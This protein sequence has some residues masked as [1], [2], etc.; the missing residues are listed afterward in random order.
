M[1]I[2]VIAAEKAEGD[3]PD[4]TQDLE[5]ESLP[6]E[7]HAFEDAQEL[8]TP[9]SKDISTIIQ[10]CLKDVKKCNSK[11]AIKALSKLIAV[12]EYVQLCAWYKKHNTCKQPCLA[13]SVAIVCSMGKGP[14]F[15]RQIRHLELYLK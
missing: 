4:L 6:L 1:Q 13:A 8:F 9:E 5:Q 15:A 12:S 10:S 11:H 2:A 7:G 14:Y 3:H